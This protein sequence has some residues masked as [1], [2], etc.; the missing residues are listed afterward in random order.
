M[1]GLS[2]AHANEG[3]PWGGRPSGQAAAPPIN[4]RA[5]A[6]IGCRSQLLSHPP[7]AEH[8]EGPHPT[9]HRHRAR[10]PPFRSIEPEQ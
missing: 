8:T 6:L 4:D 1:D 3:A 5:S 10:R 7:P 2:E 9:D